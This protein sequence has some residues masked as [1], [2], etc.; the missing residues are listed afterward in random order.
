M[1]TID[2]DA[3]EARAYRVRYIGANIEI[4]DSNGEAVA[5]LDGHDVAIELLVARANEGAG[6]E[7]LFG[8]SGAMRW[9]VRAQAAEAELCKIADQRIEVGF[10]RIL[11]LEDMKVR[12]ESAE[13]KVAAIASI[14][15]EA[16]VYDAR[17]MLDSHTV[18]W[19]A[20]RRVIAA[21]ALDSARVA[22]KGGGGS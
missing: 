20:I 3:I 9:K 12:A 6:V 19:A 14:I 16:D 2:V 5:K 1:T 17:S 21:L 7:V 4:V 18:A 10:D 13:A 22:T 15:S 11:D 8:A